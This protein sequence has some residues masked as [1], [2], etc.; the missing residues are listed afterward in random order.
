M[1]ERDRERSNQIV[2]VIDHLL[3]TLSSSTFSVAEGEEA[4]T[5]TVFTRGSGGGRASDL[6]NGGGRRPITMAVVTV[7]IVTP[8]ATKSSHDVLICTEWNRFCSDIHHCLSIYIGQSFCSLLCLSSQKEIQTASSCLK[9]L[10][11]DR[12]IWNSSERMGCGWM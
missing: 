11:T 2:M 5:S 7:N 3:T 12:N 1:G 10:A 4:G 8:D 9:P 6:G